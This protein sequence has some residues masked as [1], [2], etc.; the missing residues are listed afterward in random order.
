V[1]S[2]RPRFFVQTGRDGNRLGGNGRLVNRAHDR[3][4]QEF[5]S[6]IGGVRRASVKP[7]C[8]AIGSSAHLLLLGKPEPKDG[9]FTP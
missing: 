9:A 1:A 7:R 2:L 6:E 3:F 4:H 5:P 8:T